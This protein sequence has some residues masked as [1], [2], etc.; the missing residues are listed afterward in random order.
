[1]L[2]SLQCVGDCVNETKVWGVGKEVINCTLYT[3][4]TWAVMWSRGQFNPYIDLGGTFFV[5]SFLL[6]CCWYYD[7]ILIYSSKVSVKIYTPY[8]VGM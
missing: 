1:M 7:S 8:L 3:M 2:I 5:N 4:I 6:E